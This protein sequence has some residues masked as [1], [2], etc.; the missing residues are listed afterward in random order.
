LFRPAI[1]WFLKEAPKSAVRAAR[2]AGAAF[3]RSL[4]TGFTNARSVGRRLDSRPTTKDPID[5]ASG[6]VVLRQVDVELAGVLPLALE[7]VHVSTYREG[8]L[9]GASWASTLEQRV[10]VDAEGVCFASADGMVLAY[11]PVIG[12]G[13]SV[14]P[15]EGPRWPLALTEDGGYTVTDPQLGR[16]LH[17]PSSG[18]GVLPLAVVTDRNGNRIDLDYDAEGTLAEIRHSGGYQI[19]VDTDDV[20]RVIALRLVIGNENGQSGGFVLMRYGYDGAGHLT[21]VINSSGKPLRFSYDGQGRMTGWVDRIGSWYQYVYDEQGRGVRGHGSDGFLD[22]TLSYADQMTVET[23]SLGHRTTYHFN[24]LGQVAAET[25]PLGRVTRSEWDRYDR[26]L[27][28]TDPLGRPTRYV[29]DEAGNLTEL[30][31]PD[32][33]RTTAVHNGSG[34]P[35]EVIDADGA[36]GAMPTTSAATSPRSPIRRIRRRGTRTTSAGARRH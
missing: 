7:R 34:L 15:S 27:S 17:F 18:A 16:T 14:L 5:L 32:G 23:D 28:R 11:P 4:G 25:D 2:N 31:R 30:I 8:R 1:Q 13:A 22:V 35:T 21:E 29:Y 26:L 9:F 24:E 6:E 19:A 10:E 36:V 12:P 3:R 20:G 33:A